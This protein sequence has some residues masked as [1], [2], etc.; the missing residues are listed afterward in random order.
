MSY[1]EQKKTVQ[2]IINAL[3]LEITFF[4]NTN[5][6]KKPD[7]DRYLVCMALT[8]D[9]RNAVMRDLRSKGYL[10]K[11]GKVYEKEDSI[12]EQQY[13]GYSFKIDLESVKSN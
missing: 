12:L 8:K 10:C 9:R 7:L 13:S 3:N 4:N 1:L 5:K 2:N 11:P 6:P